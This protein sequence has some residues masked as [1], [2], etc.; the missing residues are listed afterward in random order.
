MINYIAHKLFSYYSYNVVTLTLHMFTFSKVF[1][2][3]LNLKK[4][5]VI[6][7]TFAVYCDFHKIG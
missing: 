5:T 7:T 3:T 4:Y 1:S 6:Y 2:W